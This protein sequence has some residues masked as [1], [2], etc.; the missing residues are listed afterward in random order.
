M[1]VTYQA[2]QITGLFLDPKPTNVPIGTLFLAVDT[3]QKYV[4]DGIAWQEL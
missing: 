2:N 4:F 3:Q 1:A